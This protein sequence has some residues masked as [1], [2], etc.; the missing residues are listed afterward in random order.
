MAYR[1]P[2]AIKPWGFVEAEGEVC[3]LVHVLAEIRG[4][5]EIGC[6]RWMEVM[7]PE[8]TAG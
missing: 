6:L 1:R 7:L 2:R 8:E 4:E 5:I 3:R